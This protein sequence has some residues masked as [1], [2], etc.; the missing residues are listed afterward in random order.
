MARL[1]NDRGGRGGRGGSR[2]K[3]EAASPRKRSR[4]LDGV[5][6][7]DARDYDFL[8]K[9]VTEYGKII[10]ARLTGATPKQQ[11]QIKRAVRSARTMG[12]LA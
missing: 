8:S 7:I 6:D 3:R 1:S 10:P 4:F 9:F 5:T 11:R 12:L 2:R